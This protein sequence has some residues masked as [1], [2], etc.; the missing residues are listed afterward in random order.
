MLKIQLFEI[1]PEELVARVVNELK[2]ELATPQITSQSEE[3]L[4]A[5]DL[6]DLFHV[7]I[8]TVNNWRRDKVIAAHQLG[9]KIFFKRTEI[10]NS[11]VELKS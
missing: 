9:G 4:S 11:L 10:E 3:Y 6:A 8:S 7:S 5:K 2:Q 1:T